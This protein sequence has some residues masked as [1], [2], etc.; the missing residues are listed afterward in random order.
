LEGDKSCIELHEGL[1]SAPTF[2]DEVKKKSTIVLVALLRSVCEPDRYLLVA[3]THLY[4][5]PK[6]DGVRLVQTAIM[7]N[8]LRTR[9]DKFSE[10][11][12]GGARI[13]T[14]IG[15]DL[16]TC[17]CIAAYHYLVDGFVSRD[18]KDWMV[19]KMTGVPQCECY[20]RHNREGGVNK[21]GK[22]MVEG[23]AVMSADSDEFLPHMQRKLDNDMAQSDAAGRPEAGD[24]CGL[25]LRHAFH[26]HNVTGTDHCTNYT[27]N[28]KS[29]LD[30]IIID[31]THLMA[32][33]VVPLPSI[34]EVSEF[35]ALPSA[36]FPSDHLALVADI[37]WKS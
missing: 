30:Y 7:L 32:D 15:G 25:D 5:H 36:Y 24:F 31:S 29:V 1:K 35:V 21:P 12:G 9:M 20:Y 6:G 4:Y 8:Y 37:K 17:P 23:G 10:F 28:F 11:L 18:H 13:A 26:F 27:A 22:V 3:N 19:Y 16:N 34:E 2:L 33:R 14:V